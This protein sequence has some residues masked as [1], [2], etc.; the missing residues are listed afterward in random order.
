M[1]IYFQDKPTEDVLGKM[2]AILCRGMSIWDGNKVS[3]MWINGD[4]FHKT[5]M[6]K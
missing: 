5:Y 2:S 3:R 1:N 4:K 6:Y